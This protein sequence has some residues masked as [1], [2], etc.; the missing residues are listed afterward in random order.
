MAIVDVEGYVGGLW[1]MLQSGNNFSV[2]IL[3]ICNYDITFN[4]VLGSSSWS[5]TDLYASPIP[6]NR[7][8]LW[9]HLKSIH[10]NNNM[11]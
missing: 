3:D 11:P 8:R 1:V 9:Q 6:T 10:D 4:I 5:C 2:T 7:P